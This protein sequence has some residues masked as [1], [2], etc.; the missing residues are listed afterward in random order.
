MRIPGAP[1]IRSAEEADRDRL[2]EIMNA[3]WRVAW[4]PNL[5]TDADRFWHEKSVAKTFIYQTWAFCLVAEVDGAVAGFAHLSGDELTSLHVDPVKRRAGT[6]R[7]LMAAAEAQVLALGFRR[8]RVETEVFNKPAQAFYLSVGYQE[9]RRF[10]GDV[11]GYTIPC[12]EFTR[13]LD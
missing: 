3:T 5:P 9:T 10:D 11:V 13:S 2:T 8:L 12:V 4:A 6:G 7:A 1:R